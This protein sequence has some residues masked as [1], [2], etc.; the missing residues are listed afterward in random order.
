MWIADNWKDYEVIDTSDGES[1]RDGETIFLSD[2]IR[3]LYGI[4]LKRQKAGRR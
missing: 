3:R 2:L 4:R 1:W